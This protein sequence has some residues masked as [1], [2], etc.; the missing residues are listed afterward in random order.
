VCYGKLAVSTN[1]GLCEILAEGE[2]GTGTIKTVLI[3]G[4]QALSKLDLS[5]LYRHYQNWTDRSCTGIIKTVL[6]TRVQA[7]SKLDSSELYRHYQNCTDHRGT[8]TIK[9]VLITGVQALS[10]LD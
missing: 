8:G 9:T 3:T 2:Q 6:I 7:L 1:I 4:V 5:E 10:K